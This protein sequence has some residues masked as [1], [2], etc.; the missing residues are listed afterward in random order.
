MN[1]PACWNW[2]ARANALG[3]HEP[4][5]AALPAVVAASAWTA[6]GTFASDDSATCFPVS[7]SGLSF[8]PVTDPFLRS[9]PSILTAA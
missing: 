1:G 3:P 8:L 5:F 2:L 9:L 6:V 4:K 7:V